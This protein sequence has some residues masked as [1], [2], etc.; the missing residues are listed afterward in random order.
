MLSPLGTKG[1]KPPGLNLLLVSEYDD[2]GLDD[3]FRK[4]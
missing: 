3:K 1:K 2:E 4:M